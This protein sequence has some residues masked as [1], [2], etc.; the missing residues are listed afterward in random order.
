MPVSEVLEAATVLEEVAGAGEA[1]EF[2]DLSVVSQQLDQIMAWQVAQLCVAS[3]LV[4][5]VLGVAVAL[6]IRRL[7]K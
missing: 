1:G 5:V 4:G 6:V 2:V 7:W 3:I